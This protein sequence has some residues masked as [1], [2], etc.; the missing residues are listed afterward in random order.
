MLHIDGGDFGVILDEREEKGKWKPT[1]LRHIPWNDLLRILKVTRNGDTLVPTKQYDCP[2]HLRVVQLTRKKR[3]EKNLDVYGIVTSG[4]L[5]Q[6]HKLN[7]A[8]EV[9]SSPVFLLTNEGL[10]AIWPY[11]REIIHAIQIN[12]PAPL[13]PNLVGDGVARPARF[14]IERSILLYSLEM[15][16]D[17]TPRELPQ[18]SEFGDEEEHQKAVQLEKRKR[19]RARNFAGGPRGPESDRYISA[20]PDSDSE[21]C[22]EGIRPHVFPEEWKTKRGVKVRYEL[23]SSSE[24]G[25]SE[26]EDSEAEEPKVEDLELWPD[27]EDDFTML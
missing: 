6:F 11:L 24:S 13:D 12:A 21:D 19:R 7:D 22:Y 26:S 10:P 25:G 18:A 17:G 4:D 2:Q 8:A 20:E 1:R 16:P 14:A 3:G 9:Q 27:P 23:D 15:N 5:L